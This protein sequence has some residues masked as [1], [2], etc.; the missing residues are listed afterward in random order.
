MSK[1]GR[2]TVVRK[3]GSHGIADLYEAFDPVMNRPVTL[4]VA[5][6][7]T[8]PRAGSEAQPVLFDARQVS[9]L[10]HPN[11]VRVLACEADADR[12]FFV[13]EKVEGKTL[14]DI[15]AEAG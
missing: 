10:D 4:C 6:H 14:D 13:M 12:P 3:T 8:D 11:I 1:I 5:E 7:P 15:L 2:Y 9:N